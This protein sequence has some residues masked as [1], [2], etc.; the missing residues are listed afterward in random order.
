MTEA[1]G[2]VLIGGCAGL[3]AAWWT[4]TLSAWLRDHRLLGRI[5]KLVGVRLGKPGLPVELWRRIHRFCRRRVSLKSCRRDLPDFFE[6]LALA[7]SAGLNLPRAWAFASTA[8]SDAA[9]TSLLA[10]VDASLRMGQS[11]DQALARFAADVDDERC[12][13]IV[14]LMRQTLRR[15]SPLSAL[16]IDQVEQWRHAESGDAE[17]RAQTLSLRLL[18]PIFVFLLPAV[19]IVLFAPLFLAA[20][21]GGALF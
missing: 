4:M 18:I 1:V 15:G 2:R 17:R 19:F 21:Q 14:G 5:E 7:Q 6:L 9:L 20:L 3:G 8:M 12:S 13:W 10:G 11:W 16:L